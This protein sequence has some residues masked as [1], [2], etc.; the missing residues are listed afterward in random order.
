MFVSSQQ[1]AMAESVT[2]VC[3]AAVCG[4]D[5]RGA[6]EKG[7]QPWWWTSTLHASSGPTLPCPMFR[8]H[9]STQQQLSLDLSEGSEPGEQDN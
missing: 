1:L 8:K 6:S 7:D 9:W 4:G 3:V 2:P 5:R